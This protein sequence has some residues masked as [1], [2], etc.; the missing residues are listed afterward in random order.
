MLIFIPFSYF[1][2]SMMYRRYAK[3]M[4]VTPTKR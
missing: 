4:G 1:M 2:D 3:R